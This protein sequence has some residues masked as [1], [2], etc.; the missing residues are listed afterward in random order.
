MKIFLDTAILYEIKRG[1]SFG[2]F[3]VITGTGTANGFNII[4]HDT[5]SLSFTLRIDGVINVKAVGVNTSDT[6]IN[7]HAAFVAAIA[8]IP[9][10]GPEFNIPNDSYS[11][12]TSSVNFNLEKKHSFWTEPLTG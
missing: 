1:Y 2:I 8:A 12:D 9:A 7:Q 4:A 3:D 10:T 11:I 6:A 5:L